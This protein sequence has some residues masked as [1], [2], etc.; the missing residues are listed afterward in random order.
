MKKTHLNLIAA[1]F[2]LSTVVS[3]FVSCNV[4]NSSTSERDMVL[5]YNQPGETWYDAM[6]IGNGIMGARGLSENLSQ[7]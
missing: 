7:I 2:T 5:W 3:V 1:L 4:G 6:L